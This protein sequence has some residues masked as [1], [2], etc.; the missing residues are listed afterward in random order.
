MKTVIP[1]NGD[2]LDSDICKSFGRAKRFFIIDNDTLEYE[3]VENAQNMQSAQGA[4]IQSAQSAIK[5]GGDALITMHCGPKAY[6]VLSESGVRVFIG[7]DGSIRKNIDEYKEGTLGIMK[8]SNVE[9]H[10]V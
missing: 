7:V 6:R 5:A 4:G 2:N 8:N 9:G 10:W 1:S 3:I